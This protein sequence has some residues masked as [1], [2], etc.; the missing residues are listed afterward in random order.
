MKLIYHFLFMLLFLTGCFEKNAILY[1]PSDKQ[2]SVNAIRAK[3]AHK[4]E[5][6]KGLIPCGTGAQ[7][8]HQIKMLALAFDYRKPLDIETGRHFLVEAVQEF[9]SAIN[10]D[11]DIRPYL[12]NYPFDAKNVIIEICLQNQ[13]G[14]D[15]GASELCIIES[16]EGVLRYKIHDSNDRLKTVYT[17][18]YDEALQKVSLG[19]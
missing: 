5:K 18:T 17:E 4:L 3:V 19:K 12:D 11:N 10:A 16:S 15:L 14:S 7:M 1:H 9:T 13:N 6:E 8:M 2:K